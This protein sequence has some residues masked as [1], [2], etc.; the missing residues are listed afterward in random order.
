MK[1]ALLLLSL[2]AGCSN[3]STLTGPVASVQ[4][5]WAFSG[6][7][8][9]PPLSLVGTLNITR[10]SGDVI[11]GGLGWTESDG[12]GAPIVRSAPLAGLVIGTTDIDFDVNME[13]E[14]RRHLARVSVNGDTLVGVWVS[15]VG[16]RT[17]TF[18]ARRIDP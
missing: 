14:S 17:G 3:S 1:R 4:G 11:E 15:S 8:A 12:I 6:S 5:S 16:S 7:Q 13:G 9:A 2:V 10:Q 18:T